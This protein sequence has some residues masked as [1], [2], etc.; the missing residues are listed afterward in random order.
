MYTIKRGC[1]RDLPLRN[2]LHREGWWWH[3][4]GNPD[5]YPYGYA[6]EGPFVSK[7]HARRHLLNTMRSA[8]IA[9]KQGRWPRMPPNVGRSKD[10][11]GRTGKPSTKPLKGTKLFGQRYRDFLR[12]EI[13]P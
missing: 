8:R 3:S 10:W 7:E 2:N 12:D 13:Q 1:V 11:G 5:W 6:P 4:S 9:E